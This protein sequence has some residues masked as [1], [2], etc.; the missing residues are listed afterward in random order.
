MFKAHVI[1]DIRLHPY[2]QP[3]LG[4]SHIFIFKKEKKAKIV[5]KTAQLAYKEEFQAIQDKLSASLNEV[6]KNGYAYCDEAVLTHRCRMGYELEDQGQ[7][8]AIRFAKVNYIPEYRVYL[9]PVIC[10]DD[11]KIA[12]K[13]ANVKKGKAKVGCH[14]KY[15][16][17]EQYLNF[18]NDAYNDEVI[19][20]ANKIYRLEELSSDRQISGF[21]YYAAQ[22]ESENNRIYQSE[23][24]KQFEEDFQALANDGFKFQQL[25]T[26]PING[27]ERPALLFSKTGTKTISFSNESVFLDGFELWYKPLVRGRFRRMLEWLVP[28]YFEKKDEKHKVIVDTE[29]EDTERLEAVY[30]KAFNEQSYDKAKASQVQ[31]PI[32]IISKTRVPHFGEDVEHLFLLKDLILGGVI[33]SEVFRKITKQMISKAATVKKVANDSDDPFHHGDENKRIKNV[34]M[35]G[36]RSLKREYR[37]NMRKLSKPHVDVFTSSIAVTII[38]NNAG[39]SKTVSQINADI[40]SSDEDYFQEKVNAIPVA[41]HVDVHNEGEPSSALEVS[42]NNKSKK[43]LIK[44]GITAIAVLGVVALVSTFFAKT[45]NRTTTDSAVSNQYNETPISDVLENETSIESEQQVDLSI[46]SD[47]QIGGGLDSSASEQEDTQNHGVTYVGT[48]GNASITMKMVLDEDVIY[49]R[50]TKGNV[51]GSY[52]YG[53]GSNGTISLSGTIDGNVITMIEKTET[54]ETTGQFVGTL[55]GC[56]FYGTFTNLA[57]GKESS[58]SLDEDGP[59]E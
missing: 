57:T 25:I 34:A 56:S 43:P 37:R 36:R 3:D 46:E 18:Y 10:I 42:S 31:I 45:G 15:P 35:E 41:P 48:I 2:V 6:A 21:P 49:G 50:Q 8:M 30:T 52:Y 13:E 58:F 19:K 11:K 9:G 54:G 20:A 24:E 39:G 51:C 16:S 5:F 4:C 47:S 32:T 29:I 22:C 33:T 17:G 59:N 55:D 28:N 7:H 38:E 12:A 23:I 1:N 44:Y 40:C 26:I 27:K 14:S 53:T